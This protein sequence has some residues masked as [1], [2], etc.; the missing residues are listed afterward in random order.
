MSNTWEYRHAFRVHALQDVPLEFRNVYTNLAEKEADP[1][2]SF[3]PPT[4]RECHF[5]VARWTPPRL[6]V[7]FPSSLVLLSLHHESDTVASFRLQRED[8][9]G[10]G[11]RAFLLHCCFSVYP[12]VSE[13]EPLEVHF[14][15][16]AEEK[17]QELGKVL[18]EWA[19]QQTPTAARPGCYN[20]GRLWAGL[21]PKFTHLIEQHPEFGNVTEMFYQPRMVF[22]GRRGGEWPDLSLLLT[23]EAIVV[24]TDQHRGRWSQYGVEFLYFPLGRVQLAEWVETGG[25]DRGGIRVRLEGAS[26]HV[27]ICWSVFRGLKPYALRWLRSLER[28]ARATAEILESS[29]VAGK[30][31]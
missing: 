19:D 14:P 18:V 30:T 23:S 13:G 11:H 22:G 25:T 8:F 15:S 16:G 28:A 17:Y 27:S 24:L 26:R 20:T 3:F 21:P 7:V 2:M 9:C 6:W 5:L 4:L 31:G 1:I 12:G 10:F 29:D